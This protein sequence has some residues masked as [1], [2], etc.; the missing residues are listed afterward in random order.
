MT[1]LILDLG[2]SE[3]NSPGKS[4]ALDAKIV[5]SPFFMDA[6]V[7]QLCNLRTS[8]DSLESSECLLSWMS[9]N[10]SLVYLPAICVSNNLHHLTILS[11]YA[12]I[13]IDPTFHQPSIGLIID[14]SLGPVRQ[15]DVCR[16]RR[17]GKLVRGIVGDGLGTMGVE[18][19]ELR[20]VR[21]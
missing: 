12:L 3:K 13:H 18:R 10:V 9:T 7:L 17:D 6:D 5:R 19:K 11:F 4:R 14:F 15:S 1:N 21:N 8:V 20:N 16:E 2:Y